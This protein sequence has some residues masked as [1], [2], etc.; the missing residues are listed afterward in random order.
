MPYIVFQVKNTI[1]KQFAIV[2]NVNNRLQ[3]RDQIN[4]LR[5]IVNSPDATPPTGEVPVR[6]FNGTTI[7]KVPYWTIQ[8]NP[9]PIL[10]PATPGVT[11][12]SPAAPVTVDVL[13]T[14]LLRATCTLNGSPSSA[15]TVVWSSSLDG[16]LGVGE[17]VSTDALTVGVHTITASFTNDTTATDT[18]TVTVINASAPPTVTILS[19]NDSSTFEYGIPIKCAA[20]AEDI[21]NGNLNSSIKWYRNTA[22]GLLYEGATFSLAGL[23]PG[24]HIIRAVCNDNETPPN[25]GQDTVTVYI[26]QGT[27][28][29]NAV[30]LQD[31]VVV[32]RQSYGGQ[33]TQ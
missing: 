29:L 16:Q 14:V 18:E 19:P 17:S 33:V 10:L 20:T 31:E 13:D 23:V 5:E 3:V 9:P 1:G 25:Q 8:Q 7:T 32:G 27:F 12:T 28:G 15:S 11:I 22:A 6:R 21:V 26:S 30:A 4:V 24:Q 2:A